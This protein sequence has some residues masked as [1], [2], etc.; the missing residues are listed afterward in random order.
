MKTFQPAIAL[1]VILAAATVG[2]AAV[3]AAATPPAAAAAVQATA[4]F[5]RDRRAIL[6]MAGDYRV[7]FDMRET[8]P[9]VDGYDPLDPKTSGGHE[10]I[11]VIEDIAHVVASGIDAPAKGRCWVDFHASRPKQP[12]PQR[13]YA[14]GP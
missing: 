3:P 8:V 7:R 4:N 11:R 1:G 2:F 13:Q 9:F 10:V 6:A 14:H 12:H 5:E